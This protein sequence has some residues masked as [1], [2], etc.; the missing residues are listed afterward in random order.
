MR[1]ASRKRSPG[2]RAKPRAWY[3]LKKSRVIRLSFRQS[4]K[5]YGLTTLS[6]LLNASLKEALILSLQTLPLASGWT[7]AKRVTLAL[8]RIRMTKSL[9]SAYL[10]WR[11]TYSECAGQTAG[12]F[13]FLV[14]AGTNG[15]SLHFVKPDG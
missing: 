15:L 2:H 3:V 1:K 7:G 9:T 12:S 5:K 14:L 11:R 8:R 13:G 6:K 10:E 4:R